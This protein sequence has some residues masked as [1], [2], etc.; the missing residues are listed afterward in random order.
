M[1]TGN[2]C[3]TI[4]AKYSILFGRL[5]AGLG[6]GIEGAIM[7]MVARSVKPTQ[8][9]KVITVL[10]LIKT[11]GMLFGP[12]SVSLFLTKVQ[13]YCIS[14]ARDQQNCLFAI[15]SLNS[16]GYVQILLTA[17]LLI[18]NVIFAQHMD[19]YKPENAKVAEVRHHTEIMKNKR[20]KS[21]SFI[22]EISILCCFCT[23][24]IHSGRATAETVLPQVT[25]FYLG[26]GPVKNAYVFVIAGISGL[27]GYGFFSLLKFFKERVILLIAVLLELCTAIV[28]LPLFEII[29][30]GLNWVIPVFSVIVV[31]QILP[32]I[33]IVATASSILSKS[34]SPEYQSVAQGVRVGLEKLATV[35]CTLFAGQVYKLSN[36][37]SACFLIQ[38]ILY[39][40]CVICLCFSW[41]LMYP[42][43]ILFPWEEK[44]KD[45][46]TNLKT[47]KNDTDM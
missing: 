41:N 2:F 16:S 36:N 42:E 14:I 40:I 1:L 23:M 8:K 22:N 26:F 28:T 5:L 15:N 6:T 34:T 4:H 38:V 44:M 12:L 19:L 29:T 11:L 37:F 17:L 7:G 30:Y 18:I 3:Y 20:M 31:L 39:L 13:N 21:M 47:R 24:A 33:A 43:S 46:R 45:E 10:L 32:I 35:L 27:L 25:K 9:T